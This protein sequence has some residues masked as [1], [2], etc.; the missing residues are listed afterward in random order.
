MIHVYQHIGIPIID[1]YSSSPTFHIDP[2]LDYEQYVSLMMQK[3][4]KAFLESIRSIE[5]FY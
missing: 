4:S 5:E 2:E 1:W 3:Y